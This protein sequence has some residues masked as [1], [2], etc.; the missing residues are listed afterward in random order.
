[1]SNGNAGLRSVGNK[2]TNNDGP[3]VSDF[4]GLSMLA[5]FSEFDEPTKV[6][7]ECVKAER[8]PSFSVLGL[9]TSKKRVPE[10]RIARN[11]PKA[12]AHGRPQTL[13]TP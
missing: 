5:E 3:R 13:G 1:M 7:G 12:Q 2:G 8:V 10:S 4:A 6:A 11:M 9:Y